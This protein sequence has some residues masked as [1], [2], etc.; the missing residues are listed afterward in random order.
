M[1]SKI[2][3]N[4]RLHWLGDVPCLPSMADR[5]HSN[6]LAGCPTR[7]IGDY[8]LIYFVGGRGCVT[9]RGREHQC[10][11]G[12][13]VFIRP[14][15]PHS[16]QSSAHEPHDNYWVHFDFRS[17]VSIDTVV[18]RLFPRG[19]EKVAIGVQPTLIHLYELLVMEIVAKGVGYAS[20]AQGL[21]TAL[22]ALVAR[23]VVASRKLSA[24]PPMVPTPRHRL[25]D[26]ALTLKMEAWIEE[27]LDE[28]IGVEDLLQTFPVGR[29]RLFQLFR[30]QEGLSPVQFVLRKRLRRAELLLASTDLSIK[31]IS[32]S[33]GFPD[34]LYFS[35]RFRAVYGV[36]PRD[37]AAQ[38][39]V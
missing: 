26:L 29:S 4:D 21:F 37:F 24:V 30:Q 12:D 3:P 23:E 25:R 7:I 8:E 11:A 10:E 5:Q 27:H 35:R 38:L 34:P 36:S 1:D 6:P 33:C 22:F 39:L 28:P 14:Y 31:E 18:D 15:E 9:I 32:H 16:I 13:V 19:D 20:A 2:P 17:G